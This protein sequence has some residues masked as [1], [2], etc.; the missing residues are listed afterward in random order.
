MLPAPPTIS[1]PAHRGLR[2]AGLALAGVLLAAQSGCFFSDQGFSPPPSESFYFPTGIV[3]SPGRSALYVANS[4]F[5]LQ[6]N[7][8]TVQVLDLAA[9]RGSI[10]AILGRRPLAAQ[11]EVDGCGELSLVPTL[12]DRSAAASR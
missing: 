4:D 3:T 9:L 7:G 2:A 10:A 5:D 8:G 12:N 1:A 11:G 6:Y